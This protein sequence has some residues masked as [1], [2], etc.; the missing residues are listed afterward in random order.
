MSKTNTKMKADVFGAIF[1]AFGG[2]FLLF[3]V[4]MILVAAESGA[5]A[6]GMSLG[7]LLYGLVFSFGGLFIMGL[8]LLPGKTT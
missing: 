4:Y 5:L 8:T 3:G 6:T 2:T 1:F 7:V